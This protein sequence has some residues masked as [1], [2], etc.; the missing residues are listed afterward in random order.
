MTIGPCWAARFRRSSLAHDQRPNTDCRGCF[1]TSFWTGNSCRWFPRGRPAARR[2]YTLG[3]HG[4]RVLVEQLGYGPGDLRWSRRS[5]LSWQ[6][7][8]HTLQIND[9]R[10]AITLA[11]RALG[12]VLADWQDEGVLGRTRT[13]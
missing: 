9:V 11:A 6:F 3:K 12:W 8:E 5:R 4:V 2:F 10:V 7:L 13:M 1:S